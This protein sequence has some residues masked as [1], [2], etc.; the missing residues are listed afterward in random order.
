MNI[1]VIFVHSSAFSSGGILVLQ[2][3]MA[4]LARS[5]RRGNHHYLFFVY[6]SVLI[7]VLCESFQW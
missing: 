1:Y 5:I 2:E 4:C 7:N 6:F 3:S